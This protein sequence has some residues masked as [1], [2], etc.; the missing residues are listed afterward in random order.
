MYE[1]LVI[2]T[3]VGWIIN[4][5]FKK[6]SLKRKPEGNFLIEYT[7]SKF[8]INEKN[9]KKEIYCLALFLFFFKQVPSEVNFVAT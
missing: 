8:L 3:F 4:L 2:A 6:F 1:F 7:E 5:S 9:S